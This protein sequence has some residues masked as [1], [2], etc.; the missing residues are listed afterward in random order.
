MIRFI[1]FIFIFKGTNMRYRIYALMIVTCMTLVSIIGYLAVSVVHNASPLQRIQS[2]QEIA[3]LSGQYQ[4]RSEIDQI[5]NYEPRISNYARPSQHD[6][7]VI[8]GDINEST[9]SSQITVANAN[10]IMLEVRREEVREDRVA[11]RGGV[12]EGEGA[13]RRL[14]RRDCRRGGG[15]GLQL[16][17]QQQRR[18]VLERRRRRRRGGDHAGEEDEETDQRRR[19]RRGHRSHDVRAV[20]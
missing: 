10:G 9:Q 8:S 6:Q 12:V 1:I 15:G 2:S 11:G 20:A 3:K 17:L 5:R 19:R 14:R 18:A 16:A 7:F 13:G 4:F